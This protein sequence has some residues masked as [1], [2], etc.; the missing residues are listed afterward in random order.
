MDPFPAPPHPSPPHPYAQPQQQP[1]IKP[2]SGQTVGFF[3]SFGL[4]L[5]LGA[6]M[7]FVTMFAPLAYDSCGTDC[8]NVDRW[9]AFLVTSCVVAAVSGL[10]SLAFWFFNTKVAWTLSI[11]VWVSMVTWLVVLMSGSA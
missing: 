8:S 10:G 11:V 9:M 3:I 4:Q 2:Q 6:L 5:V 1:S 7:V